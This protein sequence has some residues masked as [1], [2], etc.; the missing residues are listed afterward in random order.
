MLYREVGVSSQAAS[1]VA[2]NR[3]GARERAQAARGLTGSQRVSRL[4][5]EEDTL[6]DREAGMQIAARKS[7]GSYVERVG[8]TPSTIVLNAVAEIFSGSNGSPARFITPFTT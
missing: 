4:A 1:G 6:T 8:A 3:L 7:A 2:R 5:A